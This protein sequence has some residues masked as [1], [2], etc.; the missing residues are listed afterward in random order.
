MD[1]EQDD[2]D[3][4]VVAAQTFQSFQSAESRHG[5]VQYRYIG[6]ERLDRGQNFLAVAGLSHH[7]EILLGFQETTQSFPHD[8]VVVSNQD[9]DH[10]ETVHELEHWARGRFWLSEAHRM[11]VSGGVGRLR[12]PAKSADSG[13]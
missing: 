10:L 1:R 13:L 12:P 2:L 7:L 4:G 9:R 8:A 6:T 3:V 11:T 5:D